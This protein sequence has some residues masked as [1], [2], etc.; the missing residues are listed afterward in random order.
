MYR[1]AGP[2]GEGCVCS[3]R[4][5]GWLQLAAS[6][7]GWSGLLCIKNRSQLQLCSTSRLKHHTQQGLQQGYWTKGETGAEAV[8]DGSY[9]MLETARGSQGRYVG[10]ESDQQVCCSQFVSLIK[11]DR[12]RKKGK[13]TAICSWVLLSL[14]PPTSYKIPSKPI[15]ANHSPTFLTG[16]T[17]TGGLKRTSDQRSPSTAKLCVAGTSRSWLSSLFSTLYKPATF[18]CF[19][20]NTSFS[21]SA[22]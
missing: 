13:I 21:Q 20:I 2:L 17:G 10:Q 22:F 9:L 14:Q 1:A 19:T 12:R 5:M 6:P 7:G 18:K 16:R 8:K 15:S 3:Y 4:A 11:L